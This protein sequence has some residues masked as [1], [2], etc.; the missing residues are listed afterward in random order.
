MV[1]VSFGGDK[2]KS[3]KIRLLGWLHNSVNTLKTTEL[4]TLKGWIWY[5]NYL[6]K[7]LLKTIL[8]RILLLELDEGPQILETVWDTS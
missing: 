6:S 8:P 4:Y 1:Q 3:S 5:V 2:K 7:F